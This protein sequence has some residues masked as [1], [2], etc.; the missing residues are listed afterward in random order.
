VPSFVSGV[1]DAEAE[2]YKLKRAETRHPDEFEALNAVRKS[3]HDLKDIGDVTEKYF[4]GLVRQMATPH[5]E[6]AARTRSAQEA[7]AAAVAE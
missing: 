3:L 7:V 6:T 2:M 4:S 5:A 1:S